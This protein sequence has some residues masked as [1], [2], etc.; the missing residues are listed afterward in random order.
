[1]GYIVEAGC[2]IDGVSDGVATKRRI[3]VADGYIRWTGSWEDVLPGAF[4]G[5]PVVNARNYTMMPG[6]IDGHVH[7][8]NDSV[9]DRGKVMLSDLPGAATLRALRNA[10]RTLDMGFTT[11]RD[12]GGLEVLALRDAGSR[13]EYVIPRIQAAGYGICGTGGHMDRDRYYNA[14]FLD[15]PGVADSPGEARRVART[16]LRL[17]ADFVKVNATRGYGGKIRGHQEMTVDELAAVTEVVHKVGMRVASHAMGTDGIRAS[18]DAGVDSIEHGFWL[19]E[20]LAQQ[21]AAQGTFLLPTAATLYRN[22]TRGFYPDGLDE[23][24]LQRMHVLASSARDA[25][26]DSIAIAREHGVKVALG[27]DMGGGPFLHHGENATELHQLVEAGLTPDEAIRAGTSV[28]AELL[29]LD[30]EVGCLQEG[31]RADFLLLQDN[32]LEDISVLS[33]ENTFA[34]VFLEGCLVRAKEDFGK[35]VPDRF[36]KLGR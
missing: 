18:L 13:G 25:M 35:Q 21:M 27:S 22:V 30:R 17:G 15:N 6:L 36:R 24:A 4:A 32:P 29:D 14:R 1:M 34:G 9:A 23:P 16:L 28:V 19:T 11:V 31:Y 10:E 2:M 8:C 20:E 5:L 33:D 26:F 7:L 12:C 3:A